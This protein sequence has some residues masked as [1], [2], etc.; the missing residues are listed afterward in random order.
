MICG[1]V[2][3]KIR[4]LREMSE[5]FS[6]DY[7]FKS[8][9]QENAICIPSV[10]PSCRM[11]TLQEYHSLIF[12]GKSVKQVSASLV[13]ISIHL[14]P[15]VSTQENFFYPSPFNALPCFVSVAA[16]NGIPSKQ[17]NTTSSVGV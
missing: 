8:L 2:R 12:G 14:Q 10:L 5:Y 4:D 16:S 6:L 7:T 9:S 13:Q 3:A 17:T 1:Y 15:P 11:L